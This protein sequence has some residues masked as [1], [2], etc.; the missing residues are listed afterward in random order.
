MRILY[1][2]LCLLTGPAALPAQWRVTLLS[3]TATSHGDA[4]DDIDP[5]HPE[6]H[7]E[8]PFSLALSLTRR[9]RAWR[10]GAEI[11]YLAADLAELS[12]SAAVST[13]GVL[14]GWGTAAEI[15]RRVAGRDGAPA[16]HAVAGVAMDRWSFDLAESAPRWRVSIR[17]ALEAEFPFGASWGAVIRGQ[18]AGGPSFFEQEELPEG[19][20]PRMAVR[21]GML[22]GVSRRL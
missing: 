7:A 13:R 6:I 12:G 18:V 22:L 4:R 11:H 21:I 19:F 9:T 2:L 14:K 3:G 20:A 15:A 10:V 17:G 8:N 5:A 16:L 1:C